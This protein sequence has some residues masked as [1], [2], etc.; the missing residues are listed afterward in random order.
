VRSSKLAV[1]GLESPPIDTSVITQTHKQVVT[2]DCKRS[3]LLTDY[4]NIVVNTRYTKARARKHA[5]IRTPAYTHARARIY[6]HTWAH[7]HAHM[8]K[9]AHAQSY[10]LTTTTHIVQYYQNASQNSICRF[11]CVCSKSEWVC[12][13][14]AYLR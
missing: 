14:G 12:F 13:L 5:R 11:V 7:A 1:I 4:I 6:T 2:S 8:F 9:R 3:I 10:L